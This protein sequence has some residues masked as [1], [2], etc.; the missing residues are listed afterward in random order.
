MPGTPPEFLESVSQNSGEL[1]TAKASNGY[2][3][4]ASYYQGERV[5]Q[6]PRTIEN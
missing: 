5:I 3:H 2:N 6:Q 4:S 1:A